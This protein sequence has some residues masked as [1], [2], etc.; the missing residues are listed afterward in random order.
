M[1]VISSDFSM[2]TQ[3]QLRY[4]CHLHDMLASACCAFGGFPGRCDYEPDYT[5]RSLQSVS[6]AFSISRS[7]SSRMARQLG[8]GRARFQPTPTLLIFHQL[9]LLLQVESS[10]ASFASATEMWIAAG[11]H[12][13]FNHFRTVDKGNLCSQSLSPSLIKAS[14]DTACVNLHVHDAGEKVRRLTDSNHRLRVHLSWTTQAL[15]TVH[16]HR[17]ECPSRSQKASLGNHPSWL[18]WARRYC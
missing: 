13:L 17:S 12:V 11:K 18:H 10:L 7:P 4:T 6:K 9:F 14:N 2:R 1:S 8:S 15:L 3:C 5:R 16:I